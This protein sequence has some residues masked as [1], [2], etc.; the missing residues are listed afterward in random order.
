MSF[1]EPSTS[2]GPE[3]LTSNPLT[4]RLRDAYTAFSEKRES[5]GLPYPGQMEDLSKEVSRGV[6]L[7]LYT[8]TGFRADLTKAFS[9]TPMFQVSHALSMGSQAL[10]PYTFAALYGS[11][12]VRNFRL[13]RVS[14]YLH[15][16]RYSCK[17]M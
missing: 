8:F 11:P 3:W 17:A 1:A 14:A 4:L 6:F 5:L 9:A 7:N 2:T 16:L 15:L 12:K 10:P 13:H